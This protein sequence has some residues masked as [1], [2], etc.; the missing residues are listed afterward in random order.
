[1][2]GR[3]TLAISATQLAEYIVKRY[4]ITSQ[5]PTVELPQFN[6]APG[7]N[8][9]SILHDGKKYRIG[10][11]KWG[12]VNEL[13]ENDNVSFSMINAKAETLFTRPTFKDAALHRRCV[14]LADS[15]YE[16]NKLDKNQR[17]RR[18][19]TTDQKIFPMAGIWTTVTKKDGSKMHT[20]AI[21]TTTANELVANLHDRMPVILDEASEAVWLNPVIVDQ[22]QLEKL[23]KPYQAHFMTMHQVTKKIGSPSFDTEEAIDPINDDDDDP[24]LV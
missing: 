3:F 17:P 18:I 9:V 1:M 15:F 12:F 6:V 16:W 24:K 19:L 22:G 23:L 2:C 20:V 11:L 7:Q 14:I 13:D 4:Q 5:L 21:V 10:T 8:I